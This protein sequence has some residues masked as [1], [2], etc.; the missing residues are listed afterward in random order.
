MCK[1]D[2][3]EGEQTGRSCGGILDPGIRAVWVLCSM[4]RAVGD[5]VGTSSMIGVM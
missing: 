3:A 2:R 4:P 5:L 1:M